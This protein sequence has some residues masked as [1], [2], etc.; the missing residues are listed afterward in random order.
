MTRKFFF[1]VK[2]TPETPNR[3]KKE[4][5]D[6]DSGKSK[7][8]RKKTGPRCRFIVFCN[9]NSIPWMIKDNFEYIQLY[10]SSR[11]FL[12]GKKDMRLISGK[13]VIIVRLV[14]KGS[15]MLIIIMTCFLIRIRNKIKKK[16]LYL[17]GI[18]SNNNQSTLN[19]L[20]GHDLIKE[21]IYVYTF[22]SRQLS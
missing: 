12:K 19:I 20:S 17:L 1:H 3:F 7:I 9:S 16:R 10:S 2:P 14:V 13:H 21:Q 5:L 4:I 6:M 8:F 22:K 18:L 15:F 11:H